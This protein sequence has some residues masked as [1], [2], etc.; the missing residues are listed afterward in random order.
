MSTGYNYV[1]HFAGASVHYGNMKCVHCQQ[2]IDSEEHDFLVYEKD[3]KGTSRYITRHRD[4]TEKQ[5]GWIK[6]EKKRVQF[7]SDVAFAEKTLTKFKNEDG[8][9]SDAFLE[10]LENLG[11]EAVEL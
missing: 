6:I 2:K 10:A 4:C 11:W 9:F 8:D 3:K 7:K 5:A 1:H